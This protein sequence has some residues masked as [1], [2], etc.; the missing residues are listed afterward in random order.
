MI[1]KYYKKINPFSN[2]KKI[3]PTY[4]ITPSTKINPPSDNI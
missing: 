4:L 3:I 2:Y 1:S